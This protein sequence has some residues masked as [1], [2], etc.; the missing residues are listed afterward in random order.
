ML[1]YVLA[2]MCSWDTHGR[3]RISKVEFSQNWKIL[4]TG[5][6]CLAKTNFGINRKWESGEPPSFQ[7]RLGLRL[8]ILIWTCKISRIYCWSLIVNTLDD[9]HIYCLSLLYRQ[10]EVKFD[11]ILTWSNDTYYL[12]STTLTSRYSE[13]KFIV[14]LICEKIAVNFSTFNTK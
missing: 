4:K 3:K 10:Q 11:K 9:H 12:W 1:S 8:Q 5:S 6:H 2:K 14:D 7:M 13:R